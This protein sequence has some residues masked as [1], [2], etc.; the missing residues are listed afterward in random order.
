MQAL[1]ERAHRL[2]TLS[3]QQRTSLYKALSS[4]GWRTREPLSDELVP[5]RP[6]LVERLGQ[7]LLDRGLTPAEVAW[8]AGAAPDA[9]EHPFF[10]PKPRLSVV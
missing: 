7:T 8:I 2:G 5:E 4:R 3:A 6:S 9:A 1:I 10:L